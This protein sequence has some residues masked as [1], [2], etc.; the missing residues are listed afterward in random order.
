MHTPS[1]IPFSN[2]MRPEGPSP[3]VPFIY[4]TGKKELKVATAKDAPIMRPSQFLSA[5]NATLARINE[6]NM[7][8]KGSLLCCRFTLFTHCLL[9]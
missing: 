4:E 5:V 6:Y 1:Q 8:G 9:S 2:P 3:V 7:Q